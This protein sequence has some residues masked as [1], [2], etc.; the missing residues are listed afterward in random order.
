MSG[1]SNPLS[2]RP[3]SVP[4]GKGVGW[5]EVPR[6]GLEEPPGPPDGLEGPGRAWWEKVWGSPWAAM[7]GDGEFLLA[8]R[9]AQLEDAWGERRDVKLLAEMR[10]LDV[11]LGLTPAARLSLRWRL[12]WC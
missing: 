8:Q 1:H 3:R 4:S 12:C 6:E 11:A 5:T 9:R 7:W 2:P 10:H